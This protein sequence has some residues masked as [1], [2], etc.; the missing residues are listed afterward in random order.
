[1]S[2]N[3]SDKVEKGVIFW[4]HYSFVMPYIQEALGDFFTQNVGNF[5]IAKDWEQYC[6]TSSNK[7][8]LNQPQDLRLWDIQPLLHLA[9]IYQ[10]KKF[11]TDLS[12]KLGTEVTFFFSPRNDW[13]HLQ[14]P[15]FDGLSE[16]ED[17]EVLM[18]ALSRK[19][20]LHELQQK[21]NIIH[22]AMQVLVE[23][24]NPVSMN[25]TAEAYLERL[26]P[27]CLKDLAKLGLMTSLRSAEIPK[28]ETISCG[29]SNKIKCK[30]LYQKK[31]PPFPL[32][33]SKES[34]IT[35]HVGVENL[36]Q[37]KIF[38]T[39]LLQDSVDKWQ[40]FWP[41]EGDRI[42]SPL[43]VEV[44]SKNS[45]EEEL[46]IQEEKD[47]CTRLHFIYFWREEDGKLV[48]KLQSLAVFVQII[49][50]SPK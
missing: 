45:K 49:E 29:E 47:G 14:Y 11:I 40:I 42:G 25:S 19:D 48:G 20:L 28:P 3:N 6:N 5:R 32:T 7:Q 35:L 8:T 17:V 39:V 30:V 4:R 18:E 43:V 1:M 15:A 27:E 44:P 2:D 9:N 10:G 41:N 13:S 16:W 22:N 50:E 37:D 23:N 31:E 24:G 46:V 33:V 21:K 38:L 36:S 26:T 12:K 34:Q